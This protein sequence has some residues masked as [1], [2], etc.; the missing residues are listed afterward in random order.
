MPKTRIAFAVAS[1]AA[2]LAFGAPTSIAASPSDDAGDQE[3]HPGTDIAPANP[4]ARSDGF[5]PF[6]RP[7]MRYTSHSCDI[8]LSSIPDHRQLSSVTG[9]GVTVTLSGTWEKRSVPNTWKTWNCPRATESCTPNVLD[10][11]QAI[12]T[13]DFGHT[14]TQAGGFEVDHNKAQREIIHVDFYSG[15]NGTGK[16]LGNITRQHARKHDARLYGAHITGGFRS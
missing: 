6:D 2:V 12:V 3:L 9:C 10:S 13:V 5:R 1:A 11:H 7:T 4:S 8:D 14:V 15:P 16:L